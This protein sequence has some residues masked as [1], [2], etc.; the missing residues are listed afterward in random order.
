[1][2]PDFTLKPCNSQIMQYLVVEFLKSKNHK[3]K[4]SNHLH[5]CLV[6]IFM[7][8]HQNNASDLSISKKCSRIFENPHFSREGNSN[9]K[10]IQ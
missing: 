5:K 4:T 2:E 6:A 3:I 7:T 1:M 10:A 9:K 8:K